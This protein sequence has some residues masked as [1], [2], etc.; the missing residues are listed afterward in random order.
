MRASRVIYLTRENAPYRSRTGPA[1]PTG[2]GTQP[3]PVRGS[4]PPHGSCTPGP[5]RSLSPGVRDM[6][7]LVPPAAA[8]PGGRR[9][10]QPGCPRPAG[11]GPVQHPCPQ[12]SETCPGTPAAHRQASCAAALRK[13]S[14][15][16]STGSCGWPAPGGLAVTLAPSRE[17]GHHRHLTGAQRRQGSPELLHLGSEHL[18]SVT[19]PERR[20]VRLGLGLRPEEGRLSRTALEQATAGQ[21]TDMPGPAPASFPSSA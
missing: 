1:H 21:L 3:V 10:G 15:T 5:L 14:L 7:A 11:H 19:C 17:R 16:A 12:H 8:R 2:T 18:T 9:R 20:A 4:A 13:A 6:P